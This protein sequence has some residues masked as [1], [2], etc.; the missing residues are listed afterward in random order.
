LGPFP[1]AEILDLVVAFDFT[2]IGP[3]EVVVLVGLTLVVFSDGD[4]FSS[5]S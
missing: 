1:R 3:F 2:K 5:F 4:D